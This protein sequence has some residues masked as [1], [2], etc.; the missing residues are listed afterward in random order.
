MNVIFESTSL[1]N[2]KFHIFF[3]LFFIFYFD[4]LLFL[5]CLF[6]KRDLLF[7]FW[8]YLIYMILVII[9]FSM[10]SFTLRFLSF[11]VISI[12]TT[13]LTLFV[14]FLII[15]KGVL[16][17]NILIFW[18]YFFMFFRR[19]FIIL[20]FIQKISSPIIFFRFLGLFRIF[21][22]VDIGIILLIL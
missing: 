10:L 11:I 17:F 19:L 6:I 8:S 2:T 12:W 3:N 14:K 21:V 4:C 15:L 20:I 13:T 18:T 7:I 9:I 16:R 5:L 22:S 1:S